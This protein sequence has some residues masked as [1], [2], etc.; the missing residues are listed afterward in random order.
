[1]CLERVVNKAH[2][3]WQ[4]EA[5]TILICLIYIFEFLLQSMDTFLFSRL[6]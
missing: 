5:Q 4:K 1:M 3:L 6:S 2:I